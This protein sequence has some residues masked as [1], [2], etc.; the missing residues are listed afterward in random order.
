MTECLSFYW[1][2]LFLLFSLSHSSYQVTINASHLLW[3]CFS[4]ILF[5]RLSLAKSPCLFLFFLPSHNSHNFDVTYSFIGPDFFKSLHKCCWTFVRNYRGKLNPI[6]L[7][8]TGYSSKPIS[9]CWLLR[10]CPTSSF[11][12]LRQIVGW[13]MVQCTQHLINAFAWSFL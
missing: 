11:N 8:R 13:N 7:F 9:L 5:L 2:H 10:T 4:Q 1:F 3:L 12:E 6:L